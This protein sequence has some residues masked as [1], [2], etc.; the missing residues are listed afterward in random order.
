VL[1]ATKFAQAAA[2][3]VAEKLSVGCKKSELVGGLVGGMSDDV[4]LTH[5]QLK[6]LKALLEL[7]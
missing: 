7:I 1:R 3:E 5:R 2:A 4:Q 6:K